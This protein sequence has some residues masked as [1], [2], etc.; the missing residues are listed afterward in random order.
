[1]V[2]VGGKHQLHQN[3]NTVTLALTSLN[4][5]PSALESSGKWLLGTERIRLEREPDMNQTRKRTV[6]KNLPREPDL[7]PLEDRL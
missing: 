1:M 4:H 3:L 6:K 5:G 7:E 2:A